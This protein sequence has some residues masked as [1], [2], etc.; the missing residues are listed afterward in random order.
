MVFVSKFHEQNF[1]PGLFT[2]VSRAKEETRPVRFP[3]W[4]IR[5]NTKRT[6]DFTAQLL[7]IMQ[8]KDSKI[9]SHNAAMNDSEKYQHRKN[10]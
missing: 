2:G 4:L 7:I 3:I 10:W 1:K 9:T 8:N 6:L 5:A